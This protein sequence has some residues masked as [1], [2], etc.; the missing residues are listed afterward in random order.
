MIKLKREKIFLYKKKLSELNIE[1]KMIKKCELI[2]FNKNY[3]GDI[4]CSQSCIFII[5]E[6]KNFEFYDENII[7]TDSQN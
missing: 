5:F 1:N 7:K 2:K 3:Y 4:I 6:E